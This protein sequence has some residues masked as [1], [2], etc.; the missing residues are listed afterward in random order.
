M[1][2]LSRFWVGLGKPTGEPNSILGAFSWELLPVL[3][4]ALKG[5]HIGEPKSGLEVPRQ[6]D[7]HGF[8]FYA[9]SKDLLTGL[10][11][12]VMDPLWGV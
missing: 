11:E 5:H 4:A 10:A 9:W 3:G 7:P 1:G 6:K 12:T 2:V 8:G